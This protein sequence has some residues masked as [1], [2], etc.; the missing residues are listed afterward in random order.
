MNPPSGKPLSIRQ[1][2]RIAAGRVHVSADPVDPTRSSAIK[3]TL[4][5]RIIPTPLG[6]SPAGSPPVGPVRP[7]QAGSIR[8]PAG[9]GPVSTDRPS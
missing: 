1:A 7:V 2:D 9:A 4:I 6:F 5:P 3:K 8:P